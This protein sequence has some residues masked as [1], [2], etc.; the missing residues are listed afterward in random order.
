MT[1]VLHTRAITLSAKNAVHNLQYSPQT[2]LIGGIHIKV[3]FPKNRVLQ[4]N[5]DVIVV[6][7]FSN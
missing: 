6:S 5:M 3:F 7:R 2:Q 4:G 1:L